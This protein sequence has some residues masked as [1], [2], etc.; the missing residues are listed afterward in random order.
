MRRA[1]PDLHVLVI[2]PLRVYALVEDVCRKLAKVKRK[3]AFAESWQ[4]VQAKRKAA[5]TQCSP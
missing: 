2:R 5:A 3:K 1:T 4:R